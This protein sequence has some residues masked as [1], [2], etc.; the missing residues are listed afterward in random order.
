MRYSLA[1]L[2]TLAAAPAFAHVDPGEHGSLL[3]GVTHPLFGLDHVLA[4]VAVGLWGVLISR[5]AIWALPASFV[6][7]MVAGYALA[8]AG[9]PLPVVE[10]MILAST[11]VLGLVVALAL[12]TDLRIACGICAFFGLFHGHAHGAEL[13]E[14][15]ALAFGLGFIAATAALHAAGAILGLALARL[16]PYAS[17]AIGLVT[18]GLGLSIIF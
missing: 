1:A 13:G 2:L 8:M 17:R 16:G 14:A 9:L 11:V 5:R 10:P 6:G 15:G 3:A 18:A 7:A 4:M 12:R